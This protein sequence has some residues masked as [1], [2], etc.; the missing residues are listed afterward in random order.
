[1]STLPVSNIPVNISVDLKPLKIRL[2]E[3]CG[4]PLPPNSGI[5]R[6]PVYHSSYADL[7]KKFFHALSRV[8]KAAFTPPARSRIRAALFHSAN[9][10]P[11][12]VRRDAAGRFTS[13]K[14]GAA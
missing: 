1:M 8:E 11:P 2:C 12:Q 4:Y 10:L 5:G 9:L 6:P 13:F 7:R 14:G 3:F